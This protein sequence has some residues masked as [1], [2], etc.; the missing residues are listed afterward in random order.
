MMNLYFEISECITDS[1]HRYY[2]AYG[3]E[4][5]TRGVRLPSKCTSMAMN[6]ERIWRED[7]T[8]KVTYIKHRSGLPNADVDMKEFFW[9]KLKSITV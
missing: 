9:V 8:G 1:P 7:Q 5:A 2:A 3:V 4:P 6:S